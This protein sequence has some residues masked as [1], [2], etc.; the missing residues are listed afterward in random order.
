MLTRCPNCTT[1][2]RVKPEQLKARLG[3]VRCGECKTVFNAL[4]SLV[5]ELSSTPVAPEVHEA[6]EASALSTP[7]PEVEASPIHEAEPTSEF[8]GEIDDGEAAAAPEAEIAPS[9]PATAEEGQEAAL[10]TI[11]TFVEPEPDVPEAAPVVAGPESEALAIAETAQEP[12]AATSVPPAPAAQTPTIELAPSEGA[13]LQ[14]EATPIA[15]APIAQP[16]EPPMG[17]S[18]VSQEEVPAAVG[19]NLD[20]TLTEVIEAPVA[21]VVPEVTPG[22][23]PVTAEATQPETEASSLLN[24]PEALSPAVAQPPVHQEP[25]TVRRWPWVILAVIASLLLAGQALFLYRVEV[26]VAVPAL[27]P[28]LKAA[29][30]PLGCEVPRPRK[31]EMLD[32]ESSDLH[33]GKQKGRL[34]LVAVLKNKAP[35]AQEWPVLEV[36]LTDVA[37]K[38]LIVKALQ[39]ADYLPAGRKSSA[40]FPAKAEINIDLTLD[41]GDTPASGYRLYLYYP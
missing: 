27:K 23:A 29:C 38:A 32:I 16:V 26:A 34:E 40:G 22:A 9:T 41:A 36:S 18:V 10:I 1:T 3:R 21:A 4:D 8:Q 24:A 11:E 20:F 33:P 25:S 13:Q 35:F 17:A 37:D 15:D 31:S 14:P 6:T 30:E 7:S 19:D 12:E 2:F 39:P 5:E 28:L